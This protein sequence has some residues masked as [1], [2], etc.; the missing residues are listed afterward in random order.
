M[1]ARNGARAP[2]RMPGSARPSSSFNAS[3]GWSQG[4]VGVVAGAPEFASTFASA[5]LRWGFLRSLGLSLSYSIYRYDFDG[6]CV[7]PAG[8]EREMKR[9]SVRVSLDF[10]APLITQERRGNASR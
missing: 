5:G 9:Q 1:R 8:L 3:T 10:W 2:A 6:G 4:S 7:L